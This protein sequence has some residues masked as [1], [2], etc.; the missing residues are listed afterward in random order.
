MDSGFGDGDDVIYD[1]DVWK[2]SRVVLVFYFVV[3]C[4]LFNDNHTI[5]TN[6]R[7]IY[8]TW[9]TETCLCNIPRVRIVIDITSQKHTFNV[10][11][12]IF[13]VFS[14]AFNMICRIIIVLIT[15]NQFIVG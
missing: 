5:V 2:T 14:S 15:L 12:C 13:I 3:K 9:I 1:Y 8:S 11:C 6:Y 7:I 10:T 4:K